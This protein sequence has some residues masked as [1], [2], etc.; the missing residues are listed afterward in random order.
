[1]EELAEQA[2]VVERAGEQ[3]SGGQKK[4][5]EFTIAKVCAGIIIIVMFTLA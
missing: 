5:T 1:M 3:A 4:K 2:A